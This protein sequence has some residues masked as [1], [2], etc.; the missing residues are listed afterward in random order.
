M[1][2]KQNSAATNGENSPVVYEH[3]STRNP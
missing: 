1:S 2:M 3:I